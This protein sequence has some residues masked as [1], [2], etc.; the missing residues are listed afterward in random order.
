MKFWDFRLV[1]R[2]WRLIFGAT[3][4]GSGLTY[5]DANLGPAI[6]AITIGGALIAWH[7]LRIVL[8]RAENSC[9]SK[10]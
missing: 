9:Q 2:L 3:L 8:K 7:I 1:K 6:F 5:I 10:E 4:L